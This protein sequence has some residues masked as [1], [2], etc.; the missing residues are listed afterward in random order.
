M[1]H[2]QKS[3]SYWRTL[4]VIAL[5]LSVIVDRLPTVAQVR[6][7]SNSTKDVVAHGREG[8]FTEKAHMES[9]MAVVDTLLRGRSDS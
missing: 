8:V 3:P 6:R 9:H 2:E 7:G 4:L 1:S 5:R